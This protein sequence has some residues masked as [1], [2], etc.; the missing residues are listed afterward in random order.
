MKKKKKKSKPEVGDLI[1]HTCRLNGRFEGRIT[2][3]LSAQF[4]YETSTGNTRFCMFRED[5]GF[6]E[7]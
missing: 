2:Q 7:E 5:W 4:V 1:E 3:L 6:I